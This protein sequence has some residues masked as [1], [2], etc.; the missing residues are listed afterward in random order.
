MSVGVLCLVFVL[1][2]VLSVLSSLAIISRNELSWLLNL[3]CVLVAMWLL[4]VSVSPPRG[5]M[6]GL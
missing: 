3:I 1:Y 4:L 5:A 6:C 2:A